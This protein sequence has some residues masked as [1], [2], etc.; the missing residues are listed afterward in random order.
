M[1]SR[2]S[3]DATPL[4]G[5]RATRLAA[6]AALCALLWLG[7]RG[8]GLVPPLGPVLDPVW[9]AWALAASAGLP[10]RAEA[11]IRGLGADTR[12]LYDDRA[13]PHIFA[14]SETDAWRALGYVAARDRLFQLDLQARAGGGTL[15]ELLGAQALRADRATRGLGMGRAAERIV[16]AATG[17]ERQSLEA[18]AAGVNAYLDA[19]PLRELPLEY[20][21]LGRRPA[22]WSPVRS[23]QV[24]LRMQ[25]TLT[26]NDVD[27]DHLRAAAA[28]GEAAADALFPLHSPIQEPI[29]P[30]PGEPRRVPL[31]VP[32]PAAP[33]SAATKVLAQASTE[34]AA[35]AEEGGDALGSNN[36]AVVPGRTR[37]GAA[38]LAGDPHLDLTLP[39]V[40]YEARIQVPGVVDA[41]GV[42]IPGLPAILLG[43]NRDLAWSFTNSEVDLMDRWIERVDDPARPSRYLLDGTWVPIETR[44]EAYLGPGG[45]TLALDTVRFSHRGPMRRLGTRWLSTRWTALESGG[46][47]GAIHRAA[48]ARS[49]SEWLDAM[50]AWA[51]PPQNLLV[52]DRAGTIA[53]R[54]TGRFPIRAGAGRGDRVHDG[55]TRGND[56][57]GDWA[58]SEWPQSTNPPQGFL[59]SANQEP[60]DP[61]D[62]PRYLGADWLA[63]W[64]A[65]RINQLL[66]GDS[67]VTAETMRRW[68]TDPG[69]ARADH[70]VPYLLRAARTQPADTALA[71]AASLLA[72]WDRRYTRA[73]E[74][75]TLFEAVMPEVTARMWDELPAGI[76]TGTGAFLA[77]LD[78]P[79]NIWWDDRR[80]RN[81]VERR[82]DVL[83]DALLAGYAAAIR[84][85]GPPEGGGWRW[86]RVHHIDIDHLLRL[87]SL[88]ARGISTSGGPSTI[89]PSSTTG[90]GEGSS[91]R[92]V[93]E[94]GPIVRGWGTYPGGQSGN[95]ASSRYDDRLGTWTRGELSELR[96]PPTAA[97]FRASSVLLL[98]RP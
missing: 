82:D 6:A 74:A 47:L 67:A 42:T 43:F 11:R 72:A 53:I 68:Q 30:S 93:V 39:S 23:V 14:V 2:S 60:Q 10:A 92:M 65:L 19:M 26:R 76:L 85:H 36:W 69:S 79:D 8:A 89:S 87:P 88:S 57:I 75:A 33:D 52:A 1:P 59:A 16:A 66:R 56:W 71:H 64:R 50:A 9:G 73:S 4:T 97:A 58:P 62:Q 24:M 45:D 20:R 80:T 13:V 35:E 84:A 83:S 25:H 81:R 17:D 96:F 77:L 15:T 90:G 41:Y 95:P 49:A 61:R 78:D 38:L 40:W 32:P 70:Y 94:L 51:S 12:V 34:A 98:R 21:L 63:P 29:Q 5:T 27:L 37:A 48:R 91:W 28:V 7:A 3:P 44:L 54:T 86:S 46:E 55:T 31:T 18:Y 22:R